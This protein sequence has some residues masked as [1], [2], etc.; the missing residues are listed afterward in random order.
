MRS[1]LGSILKVTTLCGVETSLIDV[2]IS[3]HMPEA[4]MRALLSH[5]ECEKEQ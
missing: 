3:S 2:L 4:F 5:R 1:E